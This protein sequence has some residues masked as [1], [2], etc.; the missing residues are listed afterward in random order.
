MKDAYAVGCNLKDMDLI[1][2]YNFITYPVAWKISQKLDI[3]IVAR[4][5]DVW[6]GRWIDTMGV[7]GIFGEVLERYFLKQDIDLILPVSDYTKNNLLPY[8][9]GERIKTVHNIVDFPSVTSKPYT[10][11]TIA[12]VAR[13]V[14][15]KRVEDLIKALSLK[16]PIVAAEITPVVEASGRKGGLFYEPKNY[17]QLA[18]SLL[19]LLTDD[20][21]YSQL[22]KEGY[23]QSKNYT[24]EAIGSRLNDIFNNIE[25]KK[26]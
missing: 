3:P 6:I 11:P 21:L 25:E 2:G 7:S 8:F 1:I 12:C 26:K 19:K 4:Y 10:N 17:K 13:L 5:H 18:K 23:I 22:Q 20:K 16:T 14:E 9:P 15:Y 24:K